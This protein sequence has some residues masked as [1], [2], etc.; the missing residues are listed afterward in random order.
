LTEEFWAGMYS[1]FELNVSYDWEVDI[2][3][4]IP[5]LCISLIR[6]ASEAP[7][8]WDT[9]PLRRGANA[10]EATLC[11]VVGRLVKLEAGSEEMREGGIWLGGR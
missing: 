1:S 7:D 8:G 9:C 2:M 5:W 4:A 10:A 3:L 11:G 6:G